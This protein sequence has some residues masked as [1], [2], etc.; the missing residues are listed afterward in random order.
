[1]MQWVVASFAKG[2]GITIAL[3]RDKQAED[4][5]ERNRTYCYILKNR[6]F[7]ETGAAGSFFYEIK[8]ATLHDYDQYTSN[9]ENISAGS[10]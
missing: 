1:M 7:S 10:Y 9:P 3:E 6:E 4:P 2:A 5:M 8:T